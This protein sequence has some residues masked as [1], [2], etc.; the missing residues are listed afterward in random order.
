MLIAMQPRID[1]GHVRPHHPVERAFAARDRRRA[2]YAGFPRFQDE[3]PLQR[4]AQPGIA[5]DP[6]KS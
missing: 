6:G 3:A 4:R 5:G 1:L 2:E